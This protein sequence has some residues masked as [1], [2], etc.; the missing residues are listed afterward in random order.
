MSTINRIEV[1]NFLNLN[2]EGESEAWDPRYRAVTFN[3]NGQST[4]LNMTNGVGKTSNVEAWLALL[5]RDSQLIARTRQKMA[6]ERDGYY[7]HIRIEFVVPERGTAA[8][9]DFF[10]QQGSAVAG[11][12][13]WVFGMYGY[14]SA[15]S[16]NFYYYRGSLEKVPVA[17]SAAGTVTLLPNQE[18]R[19][20]LK[21][22]DRNR[23]NPV[24]EDWI[25]ELSLHVSPITMRRQAEYQKRGGGDKS[26][27]LFALRS[28]KGENYDVTFFYEVIAP[29][30]LSGL[31][32]R[33]GEEGEHEFE[34]TVLNAVMDVIRTRHNTIRKKNELDK[35]EQVLAVL[36]ET[37]QKAVD[38]EKAQKRY[39][40]QRIRMAQDIALLQNL[41]QEQ[42]LPGIPKSP[43]G[44]NRIDRL[45]ASIIIEPGDRYY[46][47]LD[48]G[49]AVL[50]GESVSAL[51]QRARR[52]QSEG[53]KIL[54]P[55]VIACDSLS[56]D[57]ERTGPKASSYT[58]AVARDLV[59]SSSKWANGLTR[60]MALE[61][62]DELDSW[63]LIHAAHR[64]PYRTQRN[65]L[66]YDIEHLERNL[67]AEQGRRLEIAREL[68]GLR[69][70]KVRME[71][72]EAAYRDVQSSG[73][74]TESEWSDPGRMAGQVVT[75]YHDV[76]EAR[77]KFLSEKGYFE[78][79]KPQWDAFTQQF[80][81]S[82]NPEFVHLQHEEAKE[83]AN[84]G[85]KKVRHQK[86]Q[87]EE[88]GR[89]LNDK[90]N[91]AETEAT[92]YRSVVDRFAVLE[93]GLATY[94]KEFGR[95][96]PTGLDIRVLQ[97]KAHA[98]V[99]IKSVRTRISALQMM[100][101]D[102][103]RFR[104]ETGT[105]SPEKW[106]AACEEE[107][108]RLQA[109][110]PIVEQ[111]R[112]DLERQL[113][114]LEKEQVA[115][116]PSARQ[117]LGYLETL[118][119]AHIPLHQVI[120]GMALSEGRK[121]EVLS[122]FSALLFA[123][124]TSTEE[125]ALAAA[126]CLAEYDAQVP[127]FIAD[128]LKSFARDGDL[129]ANKDREFYHGLIAGVTTRAVACLLDP[130]LVK[131]EKERIGSLIAAIAGE[132]SEIQ[133]RLKETAEYAP[134]VVL[135]RKAQ[136]A[137]DADAESEFENQS[138]QLQVLEGQ[139]PDLRRR[140]SHESLQAIRAAQEFD[141][142]GGEAKQQA[143]VRNLQEQEQ[144][145]E[146]LRRRDN[147]NR[148]NREVLDQEEREARERLDLA[149]PSQLR[150]MLE[151][152][153][154]F[155]GHGGVDF[156][157]AAPRREQEIEA[158]LEHANN[159]KEYRQH[160]I[161]AA[162]YLTALRR[163]KDGEDVNG[164][165]A[166]KE[167]ELKKVNV[168][169][170]RLS[171]NQKSLI[172]RRKPLD[173][174]MKVIDQVAQLVQQHFQPAS[175]VAYDLSGTDV[176][177][178]LL[179]SNDIFQQAE[180]LRVAVER[181]YDLSEVIRDAEVLQD[182]LGQLEIERD[183][184]E[185]RSLKNQSDGHLKTFLGSVCDASK[186]EGLSDVE[187][188]RM[189]TVRDVAGTQ[190][191]IAMSR[192][193]REIYERE[194]SLYEQAAK[195]ESESR[196]LVTKRIG[197]FVES[198]QDN[199][200]LFKRVSRAKHGGEQAHFQVSA[201]MISR[202]ESEALIE[203]IIATLDEE[204]V[205]RKKRQTRGMENTESDDQYRGR[206]RDLIRQ[207]TYRRIFRSPSVKYVSPHIRNDER[208]RPLTQSLSSGQ[209]TAMTLQWIIRLAEF[210]ISRE[211]QGSISRVSARRRARE[212]A[213]SILFIDGLFS[214][215]SDEHLIRE[216]MS[217]IRN[218]RGRFQL[219]GLIHNTKYTNDFDVFPVL[220]L[221]KVITGRDGSGGWVS[222]DEQNESTSD[223][224]DTV[225]VAEIR[226]ETRPVVV[227]G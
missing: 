58:P 177:R 162:S 56:G 1:A 197:Y 121:L 95:E 158:A 74:F 220:L 225:Q 91:K 183:L 185:L 83:I 179:E 44:K 23:H 147:Q 110:K 210:A 211:L 19:E 2:G 219:I 156:L 136:S 25:A 86:V 126:N 186:H 94:A 200:D 221:G 123:P 17:D 35:V 201:D 178:G 73:Y 100:V 37:A 109:R 12:E 112:S 20:A 208:P 68:D 40:Q 148:T 196:S 194:R 71:A 152:A 122:C 14:R 49:I 60:Q 206:L 114:E 144:L 32:D 181:G 166:R 222:I 72:D 69:D 24:R 213:Q 29:E 85:L 182:L 223:L 70:Q 138:K 5:T 217:G 6:P 139:L 55:I 8:Q 202:E 78:R 119:I 3:F 43:T 120:E 80:P 124:V 151:Q 180:V 51:N 115:A 111:E 150:T 52:A 116:S 45:K 129:K 132:E 214:D 131:R 203:N 34:D 128:A 27:E 97:E 227:D 188:E 9:D 187:K 199:L 173:D 59:Q 62:L 4:A 127:V 167:G 105:S 204:E 18:F 102:L 159:R 90:I 207:N 50:T 143:V 75:E 145:L 216:A 192:D 103:A 92:Q 113:Q 10:V 65:E 135:A 189:H 154:Q 84:Q 142:L 76:D 36:D 98:E 157:E 130:S 198:A 15:G 209:R 163:E 61:L 165:I 93:S 88:E 47:I 106:L 226:K 48:V 16:I 134:W 82:I 171:L 79:Q 133:C 67:T 146:D 137:V 107:R 39:E 31:M 176:D 169:I 172:A 54:Q 38:A 170:E 125:A 53:R 7:S 117:A 57:S 108:G 99:D 87:T 161:R 33:E 193:I 22:A 153:R 140:A 89:T 28:R 168:D 141:R 195:A 101:N 184:Q 160:L 81:N 175:Q 155:V 77:S 11:K 149:Y 190:L 13:T 212:R 96:S 174:A 191:V 215:L 66:E 104:S 21:V 164:L 26:A 224:V 30:L 205:A 218:T 41:V 64:N 42:P 46:R 118:D 63:L